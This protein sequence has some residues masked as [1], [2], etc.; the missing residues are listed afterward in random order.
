MPF[1]APITSAP[2]FDLAD[3]K[4]SVKF[5]FAGGEYMIRFDYAAIARLQAMYGEELLERVAEALEDRKI[6]ELA[7]IG[8]I[9]TGKDNV[10]IMEDSPPIIPFTSAL[11]LA[12]Q[13][14]W[15]GSPLQTPDT[16]DKEEGKKSNRPVISWIARAW[17][18]FVPG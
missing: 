14:G 11:H 16:E 4:G 9:A 15:R 3:L 12:W 2:T 17:R 5:S 6:A 1:E 7:I 13:Y 18:R 8:G 10:S